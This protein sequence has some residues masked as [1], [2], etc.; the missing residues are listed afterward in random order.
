MNTIDE[1]NKDMNRDE[2]QD[3][4]DRYDLS[5][6]THTLTIDLSSKVKK[7]MI[8]DERKVYYHKFD[9]MNNDHKFMMM[10][11]YL[12]YEFLT[13]IK[14]SGLTITE[15][16]CVVDAT[17]TISKENNKTIYGISIIGIKTK[18]DM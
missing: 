17:I 13:A 9:I 3:Y 12:Y 16:N 1:I 7:E 5:L 14:N 18:G 15:L 11:N 10:T 4:T 8:T 2:D 6:G